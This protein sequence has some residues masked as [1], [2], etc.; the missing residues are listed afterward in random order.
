MLL[1]TPEYHVMVTMPLWIISVIFPYLL[2]L[3]FASLLVS[4]GVCAA[5]G[6]QAFL[7]ANKRRSWSRP[8][9]GLLFFLQP[10]VRGWARYQG[11][12]LLRPG[13]L[14][15]QQT[16]DSVALRQSGQPLGQATYWCE[17][18]LD[19]FA[20]V[21]DFVRH[22]NQQSWP[23]KSDI[24]WCD[25]DVEVYGS[26]WSALQVTTVLEEHPRGQGLLRCRLRPRWSLQAKALFWGLAGLELLLLGFLG[27]SLPWLWLLLLSLPLFAFSLRREQRS[28][29][30][31]IL[32]LLDE[33][34]SEWKL[35]KVRPGLTVPPPRRA[36]QN[37]AEP[38]RTGEQTNNQPGAGLPARQESA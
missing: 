36:S 3:A 1:T 26:R 7:P 8:L 34:A 18:P 30:S 14:A 31:V 15:A 23:N 2:P 27:P 20:F 11:R 38:H 4:L 25:Y 16:L 29:Q 19:R 24:G 10:I 32:I 28:F 6:A 9:V 13:P 12:L 5:A 35:I 37:P 22:L 21:T 17:R 33:V